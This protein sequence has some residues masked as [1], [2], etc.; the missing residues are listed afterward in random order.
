VG[1][2]GSGRHWYLG[3]K[4]RTTDYRSIDVRRWHRDDLLATGNVFDWRWSIDGETVGNINVRVEAH[5]VILAYQYRRGNRLDEKY[6]VRLTWTPCNYGG[7]RPWFL[8]P[9]VGC[10]RRIA[11]LYGGE[12]GQP[13]W[14]ADF[15]VC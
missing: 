15:H 6:P 7:R 14:W 9:A 3:V 12:S 4:E 1:G 13:I 11:V 8:C 10:G 2:I 5:R